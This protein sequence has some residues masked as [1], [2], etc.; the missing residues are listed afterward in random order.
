MK[1]ALYAR[2]STDKQS[3]AS[4]ED[5]FRVAEQIA[6]RDGYSVV[7][8]FH[9]RA[10]SGGTSKRDGYQAMLDAARRKEFAAII[11][12]DSS[13]LWRNMAEQRPRHSLGER[14]GAWCRHGC[15]VGALPQRDWSAN[16]AR[17]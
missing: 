12:D 7:A 14:R 8:R 13:R 17:A 10:I 15:D 4:V 2:Y 9:D 1:A 6:T 5:Q 11:A 16:A 3:E